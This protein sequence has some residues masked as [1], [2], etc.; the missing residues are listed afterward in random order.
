[1]LKTL[2]RYTSEDPILTTASKAGELF[3]HVFRE[4]N[5]DA[6][7][8]AGDGHE[9]GLHVVDSKVRGSYYRVQFDGSRLEHGATA[10]GF[11][12]WTSMTRPSD[13]VEEHDWIVCAFGGGQVDAASVVQ[14]ELMALTMALATAI[15][16]V[17]GEEPEMAVEN[18]AR[19]SR[20]LASFAE[21]WQHTFGWK[22]RPAVADYVVHFVFVILYLPKAAQPEQ[23]WTLSTDCEAACDYTTPIMQ[24]RYAARKWGLLIGRAKENVKTNHDM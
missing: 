3:Q 14:T 15:L 18:L 9:H 16:V 8:L 22:T 13:R 10:V 11:K 1:M 2:H 21:W 12:V 5:A 17:Q 23:T 20:D 7:A 19:S 24:E 4:H 6:D